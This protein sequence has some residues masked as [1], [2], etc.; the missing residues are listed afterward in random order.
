MLLSAKQ[1]LLKRIGIFNGEDT[2]SNP[3]YA[4]RVRYPVSIASTGFTITCY[5]QEYRKG[6]YRE[7]GSA[8]LKFE[9]LTESVMA[10]YHIDIV[11]GQQVFQYDEYGKSPCSK[12][13]KDPLVVKPLQAKLI[14]ASGL[15]ITGQNYVV[16]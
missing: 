10:D 5:V 14:A 7:I 4:T 15:E 13:K 11:N 1:N 9:N 3:Y 6:V 8:S 2:T 12:A 16:E